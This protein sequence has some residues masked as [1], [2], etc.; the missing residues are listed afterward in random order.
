[1]WWNVGGCGRGALVNNVVGEDFSTKVAF[2]K[3][4]EGGEGASHEDPRGRVFRA[5]VT[6]TAKS[7]RWACA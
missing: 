2:E 5:K 7:L 3:R 6:V 4:L 1:M